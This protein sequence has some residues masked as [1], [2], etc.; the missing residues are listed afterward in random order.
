MLRSYMYHCIDNKGF[1][2]YGEQCCDNKKELER[3]LLKKY[4]KI[5]KIHYETNSTTEISH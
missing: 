3:E 2:I 1:P 4:R 5:I